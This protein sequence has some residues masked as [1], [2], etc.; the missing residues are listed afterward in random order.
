M[1]G[2]NATR[3]NHPASSSPFTSSETRDNA[4]YLVSVGLH[5]TRGIMDSYY[6][7]L[8]DE[9]LHQK[10]SQDRTWRISRV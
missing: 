3:K 8:A 1:A 2:L 9:M 10:S 6:L 5:K 7:N 4:D